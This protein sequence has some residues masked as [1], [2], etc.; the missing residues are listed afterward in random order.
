MLSHATL[1]KKPYTPSNSPHQM[2]VCIIF[3]AVYFYCYHIP[4]FIFSSGQPLLFL[5]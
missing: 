5:S 1:R 4:A 3:S 2:C